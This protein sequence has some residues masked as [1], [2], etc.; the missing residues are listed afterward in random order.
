MGYLRR[1][2]PPGFL[3]R[4]RAQRARSL[5]LYC[6]TPTSA[7]TWLKSLTPAIAHSTSRTLPAPH[8]CP[9]IP[10]PVQGQTTT[11]YHQR[12]QKRKHVRTE[13]S[14]RVGRTP[15]TIQ[16]RIKKGVRPKGEYEAT[17]LQK[18]SP[19]QEKHLAAWITIQ[20]DLGVPV[21]HRQIRLFADRILQ[22]NGSSETVGN[23]WLP[24]FFKR[25]PEVKTK[26]VKR[27]DYKRIEG[28]T[29]EVI[30]TWFEKL[31]LPA[32]EDILP[33]HRGNMDEVGVMEG[34]GTNGL[35]VGRQETRVAI[36]K[37]PENRIWITIIECITAAATTKRRLLVVDGHGSHE[38]DEFMWECY[39][40]NVH[41]LFLPPHCSHVLQPLDL[42]V[43]SPL[44]NSHRR[45]LSDII[46]QRNGL[47]LNKQDFIV[48]YARAREDLMYSKNVRSGWEASGL[49]P[50]NVEKPLASRFVDV[51]Q[52]RQVSTPRKRRHRSQESLSKIT[53]L[54]YKT[55]PTPRRSQ[56]IFKLLYEVSPE[57]CEI[58][59]TDN[60]VKI[61]FDKIAKLADETTMEV[62]NL[63][64]KLEAV[65]AQL[66]RV[67]PEKK[68]KVKLD[69]N[70]K[71]ATIVDIIKAKFEAGEL[72]ETSDALTDVVLQGHCRMSASIWI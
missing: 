70:V 72:V 24:R 32:I 1:P 22:A 37:S 31:V 49:W 5:L 4:A 11:T 66:E 25:H 41:L 23:G 50:L 27:V 18:L 42:T 61:S 53:R 29:T 69:P 38:S 14:R 63:Q 36:A 20:E 51:G 43:F 68:R 58:F 10:R 52:P 39:A 48:A 45:Y 55:V 59:R 21:S 60:T 62:L 33:E 54:S 57:L 28:A 30:R 56:D 17:V 12:H 7:K 8:S 35:C 67:K 34:M 64:L 6:T 19:T 26:K 71:F 13:G 44:K 46:L 16:S 9:T 15:S 47:P 3:W 65:E 2:V 40:N